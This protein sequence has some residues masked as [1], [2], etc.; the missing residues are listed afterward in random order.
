LE[1]GSA[2]LL[3]LDQQ[4]FQC[5]MVRRPNGPLWLSEAKEDIRGGMSGSPILASDGA[6]IGVVCV[7]ASHDNGETY[8]QGGPN[9]AI[10]RNLPG[11][12][13]EDLTAVPKGE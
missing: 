10:T 6:A 5:T 11:W 1:A 2:F 8:R 13:L 9:A 7:G 3:S 4:W 12:L